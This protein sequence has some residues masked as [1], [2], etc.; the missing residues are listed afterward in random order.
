MQK[1]YVKYMKHITASKT[2]SRKKAYIKYNFGRII[3]NLT[4]DSADLKILEIGPGLGE[5]ISYC[6]SN[7]KKCIIDI[8]DN[9]QSI[10]SYNKK[11]YSI[12]K[13]FLI[14]KDIKE[15]S[16]ELNTYNIIVA[17]QVL[18]HVPINQQKDFISKLYEHL[19]HDGVIILTA[20]NMANPLTLCE[21]YAD[22]THTT[23]FTDNSMRELALMS[24]K[25]IDI[26][27]ILIQPFRIPSYDFINL[28]RIILQKLLHLLL[29]GLNIINAGSYSTILT[30]NITLVIHKK[31]K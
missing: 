27:N 3:N 11:K 10:L 19:E 1:N 2:L 12:R 30:P 4:T 17:T 18:E 20:P 31:I 22:I 14:N 6:S 5:F 8:A 25:N 9:D 29:L 21:R 7:Y 13:T 26:S 23:G 24:I 15:I 28:V 16:N